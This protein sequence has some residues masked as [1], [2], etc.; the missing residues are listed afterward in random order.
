MPPLSLAVTLSDANYAL[1]QIVRLRH[2]ISQLPVEIQYLAAETILVRLTS[3]LEYFFAESS[4]KLSCGASYLDGSEP[5]LIHRCNSKADARFQMLN[6]NQ[7]KP[8]QNL[9]WT[10][11]KFIKSAVEKV[12]DPGDNYVR[13]TDIHGAFIHEVFTVRNFASHR[14]TSS[15]KDFRSI[16]QRIYGSPK[17]LQLG[18]FLLSENYVSRP[19]LDRYLLSAEVICRDFCK[20]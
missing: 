13:Q 8:R 6:L 18:Q 20:T 7:E 1:G 14:S 17:R 12:I 19:N 15:R 10:R 16:V 5:T 4:Y 9:K 11:S 3:T 2:A